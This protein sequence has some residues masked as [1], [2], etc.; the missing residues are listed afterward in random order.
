[1]NLRKWLNRVTTNRRAI[2]KRSTPSQMQGYKFREMLDVALKTPNGQL[3]FAINGQPVTLV[4]ADVEKK[5][6]ELERN[7]R[8]TGD[9]AF[10]CIRVAFGFPR[11]RDARDIGIEQREEQR[12]APN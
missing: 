4:A 2:G 8:T 3:C 9:D 7:C 5:L 11:L 1:M 6:D 10:D 12:N